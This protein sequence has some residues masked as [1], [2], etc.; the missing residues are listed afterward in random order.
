MVRA[1]SRCF[2][3]GLA[4]LLLLGW[5][6]QLSAQP[7]GN[8]A[9]SLKAEILQRRTSLALADSAGDLHTGFEVRM[10]LVPLVRRPEGIVLLTQAATI[11]DSLDRPDLGAMVHRSLA[12]RYAGSGDPV[13]AY[14]EA[15]LADS[16]DRMRELREMDRTNDQHTLVLDR[17]IAERDSAVHAGMDR[18]RRIAEALVQAQH[19]AERW[20]YI[21][22]ATVG[23]CLLVVI[24]LL[25]RAG[26]TGR[27]LRASMEALHKELATLRSAGNRRKEVLGKEEAVCS[28]PGTRPAGVQ[29]PPVDEAMDPVVLAMFRKTAPERLATLRQ[30]RERGDPEKALRVVHSLKPQ[31]VS[32][33]EARF[34][35]LCARL[36]APGAVAS[37]AQWSADLNA[38]EM[39]V[40]ELLRAH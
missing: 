1:Y 14:A 7:K 39:G 2:P 15:I 16:L 28:Y 32:F 3:G 23:L 24:G 30:A 8:A 19:N 35:P 17:L 34:A 6:M 26:S 31:L 36:T 12:K 20:M 33:D 22:L 21:A 18:E 25:Y 9:D 11:A 13:A 29:P 40:S 37:T 38:L 5:S 4:V 10:Q 27:K